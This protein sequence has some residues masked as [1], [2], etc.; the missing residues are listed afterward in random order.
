[1]RAPRFATPTFREAACCASTPPD[2]FTVTDRRF[3]S[4]SPDRRGRGRLVGPLPMTRALCGRGRRGQAR[5]GP[6]P[7]IW[8]AP[9]ASTVTED[10]PQPLRR[11]S[12]NIHLPPVSQHR[13]HF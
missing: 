7:A 10:V 6:C 1:M 5:L 12:S 3:T 2:V 9:T 4:R 8:R 11:L 13:E